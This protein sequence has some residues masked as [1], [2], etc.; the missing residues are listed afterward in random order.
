MKVLGRDSIAAWLEVALRVASWALWFALGCV[1]AGAL[2]YAIIM[3][4]VAADVLPRAILEGG[5]GR[6]VEGGSD[7]TFDISGGLV[8]H[9]VA[10][11]LAGAALAVSGGLIIVDRLRRLFASFRSAEP[12]R[13]ENATHLRVIWL[14]MLGIEL[15]R[16]A[17]LGL[18][19]AGVAL[20]GEPS[21]THW[22]FNVRI[23]I[24]TWVAILVLVVLAEVFRE[25]ARL[26]EEQ[27]LTI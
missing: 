26:R 11:G 4:L 17:I 13:K 6:M 16:Y 1:I 22:E 3:G 15:G 5:H 10:P 18:A 27:D 2:A 25:G 7:L 24:M 8:W 12:F 21:G 20:F 14:A 9:K 23:N 19:G